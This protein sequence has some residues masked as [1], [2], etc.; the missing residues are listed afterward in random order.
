[1]T[2]MSKF[3]HGK[4]IWLTG[5]SSGIGEALAYELAGYSTTL[6]LS[7][8]RREELERVAEKCREKGCKCFVYLLDLENQEQIKEVSEKILKDFK[9]VDILINNG[10]ISQRSLANE[11]PV[12]I[13]RR[14]MEV[15]FFSGVTITKKLLPSMLDK[16]FGHIVVISSITGIFGFPQRSAYSAA[17][18]AIHGFYEALWAELQSKG[19]RV[20]IVCPGRVHTNV[21]LNALTKSG[22]AYGVMDHGQAGGV[23]AIYCAKKILKAVEKNKVETYIGGKELLMIYFKRYIPWLFY[24]LVTKVQPT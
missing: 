11:T 24:K 14:I 19:I 8:R 21:S 3:F 2:H 12:E 4:T 9:T 18:H 23:S 20:T 22:E 13:D 17:K 15:D 7:S 5:A 16:G 10:G 1:M 6:I